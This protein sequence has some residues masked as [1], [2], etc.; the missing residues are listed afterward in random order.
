MS[1]ELNIG[2]MILVNII[3]KMVLL[4]NMLMV[5]KIGISMEHYID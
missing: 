4:L 1:L 3:E 2:I 5:L